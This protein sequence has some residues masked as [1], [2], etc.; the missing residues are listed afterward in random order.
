[1]PMSAGKKGGQ[2]MIVDLQERRA[3]KMVE[4]IKELFD[5]WKAL[6]KEHPE[7][8]VTCEVW[9]KTG[10]LTPFML[11]LMEMNPKDRRALKEGLETII[12][13]LLAADEDLLSEE[14]V[15]G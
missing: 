2:E 14:D 13:I 8:D 6:D 3:L 10:A 4:S 1:M 9:A 11:S 15:T 7:L 12:T 5:G